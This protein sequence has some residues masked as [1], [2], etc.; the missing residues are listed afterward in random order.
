MYFSQ[1][2][3]QKCLHKSQRCLRLV[4]GYRMASIQNQ[5]EFQSPVTFDITCELI[6]SGFLK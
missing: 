3:V 1:F 2:I 5:S 4:H 6:A